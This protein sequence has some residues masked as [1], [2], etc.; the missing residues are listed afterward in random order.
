MK[1]NLNVAIVQFSPKFGQ[2]MENVAL[3]IEIL[4]DIKLQNLSMQF[5]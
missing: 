2:I 1:N 5:I 4:K 3:A